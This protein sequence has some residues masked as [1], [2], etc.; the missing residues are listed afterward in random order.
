MIYTNPPLD[1][2]DIIKTL[3]TRGLTI[4]DEEKALSFLEDVSY[5]RF[6]AYL[7]PMEQAPT[8]H[9]YKPTSSFEKAVALYRFDESLRMLIF[10]AVEKVEISLRSKIINRFSLAHGAFWFLESSL[11]IDKH[12]FVDNLG[13][14]ERELARTKEDFVKE[15]S[16]KYG[17][18]VYPPAW[19]LLELA[20]FGCLTKLYFNFTDISVKKKLAR[21]YGVP[22]HEILESWMKAIGALR[23]TCAH[24]GRVWNR[25][26]P[27]MPQL[28][29]SMK[30]KWIADKPNP[31]NRLYPVLCCLI[32]WLNAIEE[33]NTLVADLKALLAAYPLV[34]THAM[35]FPDQW[36]SEPLWQ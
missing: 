19:K 15:H 1:K 20:S 24:H 22:Q 27:S 25:I 34:D 17:K 23:N 21:S 11:A 35:G 29:D 10:S 16:Q 6:A 18:E 31:A 9:T 28:P 12:R 4:N 8:Q 13:I 3:K 36:Q 7:K 33:D 26:M 14:L 2:N 5:F 30:R 32:Y